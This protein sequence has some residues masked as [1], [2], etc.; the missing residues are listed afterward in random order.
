MR[1]VGP[2]CS[3]SIG[4]SW[5]GSLV[6][7]SI[8]A[9]SPVPAPTLTKATA[10]G[11]LAASTT[12]AYEVTAVTASGEIVGTVARVTTDATT[13]TNKVTLTWSAYTGATSYNVYG[14]DDYS[15]GVR[16]LGTT[17]TTPPLTFVD[18][19]PTSLT[20]NPLTLP[21]STIAVVSTVGFNSGGSNTISFG[22]SGTVTCT[23]TTS[24]TFTGC[25]GGA[26]GQ[27]PAGTVVRSASNVRPPL[28]TLGVSLV[29]DK[30]PADTSQRFTVND[31]IDFRN[32]RPF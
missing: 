17:T 10:G 9:Q 18:A 12:Y 7:S 25:S 15:Y 14:R 30:T 13:A 24:T 8:F 29:L 21:N 20:S 4:R 1:Y 3:G 31:T 19:G 16:L 5:A 23:G 6:S 32:S 11:T 2:A 22:P 28:A 27:Y 26:A